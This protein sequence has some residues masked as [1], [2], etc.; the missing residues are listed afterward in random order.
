MGIS[1]ET[2][3]SIWV[4]AAGWIGLIWVVTGWI[5]HVTKDF[6][7]DLSPETRIKLV[8][9]L[10]IYTGSNAEWMLV[11]QKL[12]IN[13]F[14]SRHFSW[15]CFRRSLVIS[16]STFIL[17]G[18]GIGTFVI[19]ASRF[20]KIGPFWP[21]IVWAV[22]LAFLFIIGIVYNGLLDYVSLLKARLIIRSSQPLLIKILLEISLTGIIIYAGFLV[23][24]FLVI[25]SGLTVAID[26]DKV[27]GTHAA[28]SIF[29]LFILFMIQF[30]K[31]PPVFGT[32]A[33]VMFATSY[34]VSVWVIIHVLSAWVIRLVP[35]LSSALNVAQ[36]PVRALGVVSILL[37]WVLGLSAAAIAVI[38]NP[39]LRH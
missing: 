28:S 10:R 34:T 38:A 3:G 1:A 26:A 27:A 37:V 25:Y 20:N 12:F 32:V 16:A 2:L 39:A 24:I 5:R 33:F 11:F 35:A 18:L 21:Y 4:K 23:V 30:A 15:F 13:V 17:L 8:E 7:N 9:Q 14:G 22:W 36:K 31:F 29:V 19:D 6:D